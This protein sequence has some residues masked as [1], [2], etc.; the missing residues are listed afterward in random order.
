VLRRHAG[1]VASVY[2]Q[3]SGWNWFGCSGQFAVVQVL[4]TIFS[5]G[6]AGLAMARIVKAG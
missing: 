2:I 3:V 6:L 1:T 5:F 4:H